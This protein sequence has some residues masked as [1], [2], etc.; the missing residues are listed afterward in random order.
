M[1][2]NGQDDADMPEPVRPMLATAAATLPVGDEWAY[3]FKWDG[4]RALV[5]IIG[6]SL[7]IRSRAGNDVT[8]AYP[9][10]AALGEGVDDAL[11][12]G[13]IVALVDGRPSFGRLQ[14]RMHIRSSRQAAQLAQDCPVSFIA[15]DLLRLYGVD[16]TGRPLVERRATLERHAAE[17]PQWTVSPQF[18]DGAATEA[19]AHQHGLEG[20]VAK[21][22]G[23]TYRPGVRAPDWLKVKFA[24]RGAFAVIGW[25][26]PADAPDV[27]SSLLVGYREQDAWRLAGKVGS[28][29]APR[30][31]AALHRRLHGRATALVTPVPPRSPGRVTH[32]VEPEVVVEVRY[33]E[34]VDRLRHPVFLGVRDDKRPEE[35]TG[36]GHDG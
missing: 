19:A 22:L 6:G 26:A 34:W 7:R 2:Q 12:D 9:E 21:K 27:L 20:V 8:A 11:V 24:R 29:L 25:E 18:E 1:V 5:D 28:G 31:A 35:I 4:V 32:W 3:E 14:T 36:S 30:E 15:F 13:E 17:H 33:T 16:L 10:L 23:G